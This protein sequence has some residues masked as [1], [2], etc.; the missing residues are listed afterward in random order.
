MAPRLVMRAAATVSRAVS[1]QWRGIVPIVAQL[2]FRCCSTA[3]CC[4]VYFPRVKYAK[5]NNGAGQCHISIF[6]GKS[7]PAIAFR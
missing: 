7:A 2:F 5:Q 3:R 4:V 6:V 1:E